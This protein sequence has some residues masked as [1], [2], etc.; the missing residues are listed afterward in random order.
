[1]YDRAKGRPSHPVPDRR[2]SPPQGS[3]GEKRGTPLGTFLSASGVK[4]G[5]SAERDSAR[6]SSLFCAAWRPVSCALRGESGVFAE[7][8]F[9]PQQMAVPGRSGKEED[10]SV[11]L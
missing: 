7:K 6:R 9:L 11:S 4:P 10:F 1:M 5:R 8:A 3:P 2:F